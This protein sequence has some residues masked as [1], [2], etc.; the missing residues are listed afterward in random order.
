[1]NLSMS[2]WLQHKIDEY[3]FSVRDITVDFYMAQAKLNRPDCSIEQLRKFND[4]CL[5]MAE[6]CQLNGDDQS[7]LHALGKLHQRLV[8]ELS[9]TDRERLFRMQ[10][11][12]LARH[13]L[14]RLCHQLAMNGEWDKATVLQS[15]FVKH[16]SWIM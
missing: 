12:Q 15:E 11:W 9:N 5:D 1:M 4:T 2:A 13:S 10:A 14:S 6:L 8:V 7:Y 16:A 3:T